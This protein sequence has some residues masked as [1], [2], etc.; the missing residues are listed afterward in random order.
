MGGM[1]NQQYAFNHVDQIANQ[2]QNRYSDLE[3]VDN[4]SR[5]DQGGITINDQEDLASSSIRNE[6]EQ[7]NGQSIS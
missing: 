2:Q 1:H 6:D 5:Y 3:N 7:L 4:G